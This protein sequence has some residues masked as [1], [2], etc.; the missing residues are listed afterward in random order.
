MGEQTA[1][2]LSAGCPPWCVTRHDPARGEDDWLHQGEPLLL[3]DGVVAALC[4][5]V[6]PGTGERDGPWVV[7]GDRQYTPAEAER[8]GL[9]L[10]AL[11]RAVPDPDAAG[12]T[13]SPGP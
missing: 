9:D 5:S 1:P 7:I 13:R 6:D 8:L 11:A 10:S 12:E 3:T 2:C 4:M